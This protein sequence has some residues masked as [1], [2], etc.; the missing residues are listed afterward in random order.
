MRRDAA[1]AEPMAPGAS[2]L[3]AVPTDA[4]DLDVVDKA[5]RLAE[6]PGA[7]CQIC[8]L[9]AEGDMLEAPRSQLIRLVCGC[10]DELGSARWQCN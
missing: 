7:G 2:P 8:H 10:K 6:G 4:V 3:S 1:A 9:G 5:P